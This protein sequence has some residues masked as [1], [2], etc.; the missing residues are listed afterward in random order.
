MDA[1][2]RYNLKKYLADRVAIYGQ[3]R[4]FFRVPYQQTQFKQIKNVA[5]MERKINYKTYI[6]HKP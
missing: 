1:Y 6:V 3:G 4:Q 2:D 5:T